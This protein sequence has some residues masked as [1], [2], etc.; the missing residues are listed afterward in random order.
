[1]KT[2]LGET[3]AW[4]DKNRREVNEDLCGWIITGGAPDEVTN[5]GKAA[6]F[7]VCDGVSDSH[8][9]ET[10]RLVERYIRRGLA[11]LVG[12]CYEFAEM[13]QITRDEE[14][15]LQMKDILLDVDAKLHPQWYYGATASVA[16]VFGGW[17]YTA[18]LG[19]SPIFLVRLNDLDEPKEELPENL[20][21]IEKLYRCGNEAG[22]AVEDGAMS[23]EEA[24]HSDLKDVLSVRVLGDR[25]GSGAISTGK[26]VLGSNNL[27]LLGSD[28]ALSVLA[29]R[30][31]LEVIRDM[32][33]DGLSEMNKELYRRIQADEEA[34]DNYTLLAQVIRTR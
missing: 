6:A 19:D 12:D 26:A 3:Y 5:E 31:L 9:A 33:A 34:T 4:S 20:R 22:K 14:I 13:D 21:T 24:L 32:L 17:V 23:E 7:F 28:G 1:M 29:E 10:V 11:R 30:E 15:A 18:N 25:P 27:L 2:Y 8:G 16:F